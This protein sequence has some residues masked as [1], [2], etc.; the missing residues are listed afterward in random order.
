VSL[1][2]VVARRW[3]HRWEFLATAVGVAESVNQT[4]R[5]LS[6]EELL[7]GIAGS[8]S[9]GTVSLRV[10][11]LAVYS[12]NQLVA[13]VRTWPLPVTIGDQPWFTYGWHSSL[14]YIKDFGIVRRADVDVPGLR[15][16]VEVLWYDAGNTAVSWHQVAQ[17]LAQRPDDYSY[18][19]KQAQGKLLEPFLS[20]AEVERAPPFMLRL[21]RGRANRID[22][23]AY[24]YLASLARMCLD[25]RGNVPVLAL[26]L[27]KEINLPILADIEAAVV[28][29]LEQGPDSTALESLATIV[30]ILLSDWRTA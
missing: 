17:Q 16:E 15:H 13:I 14:R 29:R 27:C 19:R 5:G 25:H 22:P 2:E 9:P 3:D 4:M 18:V 30:Y 26:E 21:L 1:S 7:Q 11:A 8:E 12:I 28:D 10:D 23:R 6:R 24:D 20:A